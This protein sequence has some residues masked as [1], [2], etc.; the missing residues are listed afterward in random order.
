MTPHTSAAPV[1]ISKPKRPV[2]RPGVYLVEY[3]TGAYLLSEDNPVSRHWQ[4]REFRFLWVAWLW[5]QWWVA[6]N[7]MGAANVYA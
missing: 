2:K 5:G 1:T 3:T 7:P 4:Y 6:T